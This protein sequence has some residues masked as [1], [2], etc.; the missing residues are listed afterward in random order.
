MNVEIEKQHSGG[1]FSTSIQSTI[2]HSMSDAMHISSHA[3][4]LL[5]RI[6]QAQLGHDVHPHE[7]F[8]SVSFPDDTHPH[9]PLTSW[10]NNLAAYGIVILV[11]SFPVPQALHHPLYAN[12][13]HFSH[14][15]VSNLSEE[16]INRSSNNCVAPYPIRLCTSVNERHWVVTHQ[17]RSISPRRS[18]PS[19]DLP[20]V[21][22]RVKFALGPVGLACILS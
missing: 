3:P 21:G 14:T 17:S 12:S 11:M 5:H 2:F 22:C 10:I 20:S 6:L 4:P 16:I 13:P 19:F 8:P 15:C 9:S 7:L 1:V 18:P